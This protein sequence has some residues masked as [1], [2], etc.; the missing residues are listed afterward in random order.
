MRTVGT[1][2]RKNGKEGES[3]KITERRLRRNR[4]I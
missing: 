4:I 3:G 2:G 1:R